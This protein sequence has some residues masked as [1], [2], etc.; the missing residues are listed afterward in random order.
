[1]LVTT[2]YT[3]DGREI[4]EY[5]AVVHGEVIAGINFLKDFAAGIR[6]LVG[7]RSRGYEEELIKARE[8]ALEEMKNRAAEMG[9]DAIVGVSFNYTAM[10][11]DNAMLMVTCQGTAVKL[12]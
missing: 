1:M 3:L 6:N 12:K 8:E 10:G 5:T 11:A 2:T 4:I 9:C 7:G